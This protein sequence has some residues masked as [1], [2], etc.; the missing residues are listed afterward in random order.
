MS[1]RRAWAVSEKE[2]RFIVRDPRSLGVTLVLPVVLLALFGY[3]INF[4]IKNISLAVYDPDKTPASRDLAQALTRSGHFRLIAMLASLDDADKTLAAGGAKVVLVIPVD[5]AAD[6]GA[7]RP[8][9]IQSLINGSD[10][11]TAT[12]ALG[13]LQ[14]MIQDWV[15][16][17]AEHPAVAE[18]S[19]VSIEPD[20]RVWFNEDLSTVTFITPGLAVVILMLLAA[21]L[22]SQTIVRER[23]QGTIEGL[24]VSPVRAH[25]IL[26]GKLFPYVVIAL[27][28]VGLVAGAG[29]LLFGVP[30]RGGPLLVLGLLLAYLLAALGIGLLISSVV[31]SQQAAY[32]VAFIGTLLPTI[33]LTGFIFPV[34]SMP[35]L[36]QAIVQLHPATHFMVIARATSLKAAGLHLLW[37]RAFAL[38]A[39][40][41][42]VLAAT[43][44]KFKKA[45]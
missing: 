23:E 12:I 7:G 6:L 30:L 34:S 22:T 20:I 36:L 19:R 43:A 4:D 25:E 21:L 29:R 11:L 14:G 24:I 33:L 10:S 16:R 41:G 35:K 39:L 18:R 9:R 27:A 26:A 2:F 45:L 40:A 15:L 31:R 42:A 32:L 38:V 28:D 3:A 37:P 5:F 17:R 44:V 13:Y 8:T 1:I